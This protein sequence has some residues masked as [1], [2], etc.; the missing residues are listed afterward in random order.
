MSSG[1]LLMQG[2][3]FPWRSRAMNWRATVRGDAPPS[4]RYQFCDQFRAPSSSKRSALR[5]ARCGSGSAEISAVR[6]LV[7]V[8]LGD[9]PA[10]AAATSAGRTRTTTQA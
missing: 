1:V 6:D 9:G 5:S 7:A 4:A 2:S 3:A 10:L 8:A